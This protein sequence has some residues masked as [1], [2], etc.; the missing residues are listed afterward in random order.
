MEPVDVLA[1]VGTCAAERASLARSLAAATDRTLIAAT[2]LS[3]HRDPVGE[4]VMLAAWADTERGALVESPS[5]VPVMDLIGALVD[6]EGG[7]VLRGV[8]CVVDAAHI[9]ADL[10][11]ETYVRVPPAPWRGHPAPSFF[12]HAMLTVTQIEF[13]ST[14]V[15]IG[16]DRVTIAERALVFALLETL[17]PSAHLTQ[18]PS[19]VAQRTSMR[20]SPAHDGAGWVRVLN[21]EHTAA[22]GRVR[23]LHYLNERPFH[24]ERLHRLLN[25]RIEPGA[26]GDVVRSAGFCR[27]ATR[28]H[29]VAQWDHVGRMIAFDPAAR[30]D[31]LDDDTELLALGQDLAF[32]GIDLDARGLAAA[33]DDATLTDD[34]VERGPHHWR[35]FTDPFPAWSYAEDA[36]S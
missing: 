6:N 3:G 14:I 36:A 16:A 24:P 15:V 29:I 22:T 17:N 32:I 18:D 33:L 8:V 12:A 28:S 30:D 31:A 23:T 4:A 21:D 13:A 34:E 35:A 26:F 10:R 9:V 2:S 7:V 5:G 1:I 25:D 20:Y 19:D 11:R 27:L